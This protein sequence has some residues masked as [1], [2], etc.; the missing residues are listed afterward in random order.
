MQVKEHEGEKERKKKFKKEVGKI[1]K[2]GKMKDACRFKGLGSALPL[3]AFSSWGLRSSLYT[4]RKRKCGETQSD[5]ETR[6][7]CLSITT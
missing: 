7:T 1:R 2:G 3:G 4:R 6:E 5:S